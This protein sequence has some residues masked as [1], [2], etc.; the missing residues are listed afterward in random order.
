MTTKSSVKEI[1]KSFQDAETQTESAGVNYIPLKVLSGFQL[2]SA[3]PNFFWKPHMVLFL[4]TL[5]GI[6]G[7]TVLKYSQDYTATSF[8]NNSRM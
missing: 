7:Y 5:C 8:V 3:F 1:Q 6:I 2:E 4:T